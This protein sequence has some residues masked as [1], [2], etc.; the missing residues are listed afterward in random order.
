[1]MDVKEDNTAQ[2]NNKLQAELRLYLE[3]V[4]E[5]P[6]GP[7][8]EGTP[9]P[10]GEEHEGWPAMAEGSILLFLKY[11][12]PQVQ[13]TGLVYTIYTY[14]HIYIY[15]YIYIYIYIYIYMYIYMYIYI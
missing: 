8:A 3:V 14:I 13:A 5:Q 2:T 10:E 6:A 9:A 11:Y 1:M 12:D 4:G 15:T 7:P